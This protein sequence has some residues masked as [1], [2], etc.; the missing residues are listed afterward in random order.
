MTHGR[1]I[2][3]RGLAQGFLVMLLQGWAWVSNDS[4]GQTAT[5]LC[6]LTAGAEYAVN[7]TC[8]P[9]SFNVGSSAP[10]TASMNPGTCN[11][12]SRLDAWGW[13]TATSAV[14]IVSY[15]GA[16]DAILHVFS[17]SC[18]GLQQV[19]CADNTGGGGVETV[20]INT[21]P[22]QTYYVRV[23]RWASNGGMTGNL[24]VVAADCIYV[25]TLL[26]SFGDGWGGS[27]VGVSINGAPFQNFGL[28]GTSRQIL[29]PVSTGNSIQFNYNATGPDQIENEW[30]VAIQ[31]QGGL[32]LSGS[33]PVPGQQFVHTADCIPLPAAQQD[34]AG[35][36]TICSDQQFNNNS[37]STGFVQ[38]LN[39]SNRGCLQANEQQGTWYY[40]SPVTSGTVAFTI[41]PSANIDYDFAVWGPLDN[42]V[43]PPPGPPARCSF[44]IG[45]TALSAWGNPIGG[46]FYLT[47]S[48]NTGMRA[49]AGH[50][51]ED[52]TGDG[53]V[54][55]LPVVAG[56]VYM[57]YIDNFDVTGQ[58][59][60]LD[61]ELTDGASLDCTVLPVE[62]LDL[63]A[64]SQETSVDIDWTTGSEYNA[65]HFVVER[66]WDN[67]A[68]SP[69]GTV[70]AVGESYS[71]SD[72]SFT[73]TSP[74]VGV[75]QYRLLQVD[76]D[77]GSKRSDV[78]VAIFNTLGSMVTP[79]PTGEHATLSLDQELPPNTLLRITDARGR[80]VAEQ[81]TTA[82]GTSIPL[83]LTGIQSGLYSIGLYGENGTPLGHT[84]FVKE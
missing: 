52:F 10:W 19:A 21:V 41:A 40:F 78:V 68:F 63:K 76:R 66:R 9:Q 69:I 53:W 12:G 43:C 77:G 73:D 65:S 46:T 59:F 28:N 38:D 31:G 37:T 82:G 33:P 55:P 23:Q 22:G 29:I 61:W 15:Q 42:V 44:A 81:R 8:V 26:D 20:S 83:S 50:N 3:Y 72:Y 54:N 35:G 25:L 34:C 84:R 13:F 36:F 7:G 17:G 18:A 60:N 32:Y 67:E 79:N 14:S 6:G 47:G 11:S 58:S 24:C 49:G 64:S 16:Q 1:P 80:V 4:Y 51:S 74:R 56:K 27:S 30:N 39:G 71:P 75:N 5:N 2:S 45:E 48:Y 62:L 70:R 57:L